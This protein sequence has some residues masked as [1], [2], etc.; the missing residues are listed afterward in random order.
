MGDRKADSGSSNDRSVII[1]V[2]V[3]VYNAPDYLNICLHALLELDDK[4]IRVTAYDNASDTST[5]QMLKYYEERGVCVIYGKENR[6]YAF[7]INRL[8]EATDGEYFV[9]MN[10]DIRA[11]PGWVDPLVGMLRK[12]PDIVCVQPKMIN[13]HGLLMGCG[14]GGTNKRRHIRGWMKAD[15]G[16]FNVPLESVALCGACLMYPR[17]VFDKVGMYD[18]Q[19]RFYF[20]ESAHLFSCRR[21]GYKVFYVPDSVVVHYW[22]KSPKENNFIVNNA[23]KDGDRLFNMQF[24][25]MMGDE[26][27]Y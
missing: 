1:D 9:C 24:L 7:A 6:G 12:S 11:L 20:E 8:I 3:V 17:W 16:Q 19:Y 4:R 5:H 18:E 26:R 23:F 14:V 10:S 25:D 15:N 13:E 27:E 2:G 22:N 21:M